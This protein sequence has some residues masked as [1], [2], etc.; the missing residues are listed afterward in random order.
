V[1]GFF[2]DASA[3]WLVNTTRVIRKFQS[4]KTRTD[5]STN[6]EL[7]MEIRNA[8]ATSK[9]RDCIG[10]LLIS[11]RRAASALSLKKNYDT[12]CHRIPSKIG[13]NQAVSGL[14]PPTES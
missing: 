12:G 7:K 11:R 9:N 1:E 6:T 8:V 3:K 4:P 14:H 2:L 10:P 5:A 13:N